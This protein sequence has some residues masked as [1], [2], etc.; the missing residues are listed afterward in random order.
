MQMKI[1]VSYTAVFVFPPNGLDG[2]EFRSVDITGND[3]TLSPYPSGID[4]GATVI[5]YAV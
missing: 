2:G 5:R 1:Q 4:D 3:D